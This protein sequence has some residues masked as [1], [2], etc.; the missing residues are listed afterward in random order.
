MPDDEN[1]GTLRMQ[2][3]GRWAVCQ[4]GHAPI[5]ITSGEVFRIEVDGVLRITCMEH[6]PDGDP[7]GAYHSIDGYELRDGIRAAIGAQRWRRDLNI[8]LGLER[9]QADV[10]L[11]FLQRVGRR[12]IEAA[13][14]A[15]RDDMVRFDKASERLCAAL[16]KALGRHQ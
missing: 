7:D 4:P 3:S 9:E 8:A 12:Q 2:P 13:F 6:D 15:A 1:V 16:A 11:R 10:L 14:D 5:E